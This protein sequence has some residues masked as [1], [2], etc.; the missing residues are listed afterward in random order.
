MFWHNLVKSGISCSMIPVSPSSIEIQF[1][2]LSLRERLYLPVFF[3]SDFLSMWLISDEW[4]I[5]GSEKC[6]LQEV[7]LKERDIC[8]FLILL[9]VITGDSIPPYT[10][11]LNSGHKVRW[12]KWNPIWFHFSA[13]L[14]TDN[15]YISILVLFFEVFVTCSC[16]Q[17]YSIPGVTWR[18]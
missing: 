9:P 8:F 12:E 15:K 6:K 10:M 4:G 3:S 1:P 16:V 14:L 13:G 11:K 7:S 5:N 17:S 2:S 18:Y